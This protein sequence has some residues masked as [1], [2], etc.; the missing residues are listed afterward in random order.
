MIPEALF[1]IDW[2]KI[3]QHIGDALASGKARIIDGVARDSQSYKILKHIP[4][5]A[6]TLDHTGDLAQV[7]QQVRTLTSVVQ[8]STVVLQTAIALSTAVTV[9]PSC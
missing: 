5:R 2:T 7:A 9:G 4:F 6:V 8:Q 3:P 1:T